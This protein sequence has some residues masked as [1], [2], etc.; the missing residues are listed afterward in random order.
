LGAAGNFYEICRVFGVT[1]K[2]IPY[3]L[4]PDFI[5]IFR[6]YG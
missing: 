4:P 6:N 1:A 2:A 5:E 3:N